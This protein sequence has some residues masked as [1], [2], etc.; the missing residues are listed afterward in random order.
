[1]MRP[2]YF[3]FWPVALL[4]TSVAAVVMPRTYMPL[5]QGQ[6]TENRLSDPAIAG[7]FERQLPGPRGVLTETVW[8]KSGGAA[9]WATRYPDQKTAVVDTGSWK[10]V[11]AVGQVPARLILTLALR[12]GE[13]ISH[14]FT[15]K[16]AWD[17]VQIMPV[18]C[19][20]GRPCSPT[21]P[22]VRKDD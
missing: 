20:P 9:A 6:L 15:T 3:R 8:I 13:P 2:V 18:S 17:S 16:F 12:N 5:L 19:D 4:A 11:P 10:I 14:P 22:F 7:S 21:E 1:M